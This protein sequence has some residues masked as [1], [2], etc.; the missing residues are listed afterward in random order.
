VLIVLFFVWVALR[1]ASLQ[2]EE[3]GEVY[4]LVSWI[5][6]GCDIALLFALEALFFRYGELRPVS[7]APSS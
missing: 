1:V 2:S 4:R 7:D 5:A 6:I 3:H